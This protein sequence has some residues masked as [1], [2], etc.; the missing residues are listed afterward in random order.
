MSDII[1]G[2][3]LI[4]AGVKIMFHPRFSDISGLNFDL[5]GYNMPLGIA[6]ILIGMGFIWFSCKKKKRLSK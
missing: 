2:I 4:L 5:T 6:M 3:I 1:L